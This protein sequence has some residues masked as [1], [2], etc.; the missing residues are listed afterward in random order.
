MINQ[1]NQKEFTYQV[2]DYD[3]VKY[4]NFVVEGPENI[5]VN[6]SEIETMRVVCSEMN[7]TLNLSVNDSFQ[8]VKIHKVNGKTEFTMILIGFK[9]ES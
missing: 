5:V 7:L 8:P 1:P 6:Q 4:L 3:G 9:G 2:V